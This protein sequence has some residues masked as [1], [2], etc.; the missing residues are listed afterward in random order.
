MA[1]DDNRSLVES[2]YAA[3][4]RR[5]L[6][7]ILLLVSPKII[8]RA[9]GRSFDIPVAHVWR[10]QL[11]RRRIFIHTLRTRSWWKR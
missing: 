5:D 10:T 7:R 11:G 3:F 9:S 6:D 1:M 4:T 2:L 8:I